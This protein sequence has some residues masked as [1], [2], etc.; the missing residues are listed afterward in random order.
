LAQIAQQ[1]DGLHEGDKQLALKEAAR[2]WEGLLEDRVQQVQEA[3]AVE[4]NMEI[5][6]IRREC[7]ASLRDLAAKVPRSSST[8]SVNPSDILS[9]MLTACT[10]ATSPRWRHA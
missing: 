6:S 8:P 2:Q 5:E 9:V 10:R 3:M 1:K 4:H 7:E